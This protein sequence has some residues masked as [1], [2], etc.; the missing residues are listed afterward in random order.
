MDNVA[1]RLNALK[2]EYP[3]V[4]VGISGASRRQIIQIFEGKTHIQQQ[5][6][7]RSLSGYGRGTIA[8]RPKEKK[9]SR[10]AT[11][12]RNLNAGKSSVEIG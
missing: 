6:S 11:E 1:T 12:K 5:R 7:T 2:A 4:A 9:V 8:E 10:R 3:Y